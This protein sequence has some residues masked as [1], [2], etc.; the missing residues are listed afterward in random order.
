MWA[1]PEGESRPETPPFRPLWES[2]FSL[3]GN[4][5]NFQQLSAADHSDFNKVSS[6]LD[7]FLHNSS[8]EAEQLVQAAVTAHDHQGLLQTES[9]LPGLTEAIL[10]HLHN[11]SLVHS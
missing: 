9:S 1:P 7:D 8:S 3:N 11:H 6:A 4:R 2:R 5:S 10:V